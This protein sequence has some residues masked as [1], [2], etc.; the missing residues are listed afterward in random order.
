MRGL[1]YR[2]YMKCIDEWKTLVKFEIKI[3]FVREIK[4][5]LYEGCKNEKWNPRYL[6]PEKQSDGKLV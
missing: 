2:W 5:K 1:L 4:Y 6:E 3:Y